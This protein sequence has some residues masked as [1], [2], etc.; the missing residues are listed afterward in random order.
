MFI[1]REVQ[2]FFASLMCVTFQFAVSGVIDLFSAVSLL[3]CLCKHG[4]GIIPVQA[5]RNETAVDNDV[6]FYIADFFNH[7]KCLL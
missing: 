3:W 5:I 6:I 2:E 7:T 4:A 1:F